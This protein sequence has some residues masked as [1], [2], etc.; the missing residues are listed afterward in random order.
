MDWYNRNDLVVDYLIEL[1]E[2]LEKREKDK[3]A[4]K[5]ILDRIVVHDFNF[6]SI[7]Q[8]IENTKE[9]K[10]EKHLNFLSRFIKKGTHCVYCTDSNVSSFPKFI[11]F[12]LMLDLFL[13]KI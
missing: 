5:A 6:H 8:E 11:V 4:I 12:S 1:F 3:I 10:L 7:I 2:E 9:T 13:L